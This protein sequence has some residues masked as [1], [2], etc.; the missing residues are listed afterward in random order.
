[1]RYT[2]RLITPAGHTPPEPLQTPVYGDSLI[3]IEAHAGVMLRSAPVGSRVD[4]YERADVLRAT[5]EKTKGEKDKDD[6]ITKTLFSGDGCGAPAAE[7]AQSG[8]ERTA[9]KKRS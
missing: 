1:M 9:G 7:L 3:S 6:F 8:D 5:F 4:L 2:A